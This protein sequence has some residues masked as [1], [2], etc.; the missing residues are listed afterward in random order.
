[1]AAAKGGGAVESAYGVAKRGGRH[2]GFLKQVEGWSPAQRARAHRNLQ[3]RIEQHEGYIDNPTSHVPN[4]DKLAT[5][6]Q[7]GLLKHWEKEINNFSEQQSIIDA[8]RR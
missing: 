4:W 1:S 7:Q 6:E 5:R 2:S 8:V 3:D